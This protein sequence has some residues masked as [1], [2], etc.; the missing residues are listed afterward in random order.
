MKANLEAFAGWF[1]RRA[2]LLVAVAI[3][4]G[5]CANNGQYNYNP[6]ELKGAE[7]LPEPSNSLPE[8]A[9]SEYVISPRDVL[10]VSFLQVPD[11]NRDAL[12]NSKGDVSLAL[13]GNIH[14][15]GKTMVEAQ[16]YITA[17]YTKSYLKSPQITVALSKSG[18]RV[19]MN[20]AVR[21]PTLLTVDGRLTLLQAIAQAGGVSDTANSDRVHIVRTS[22]RSEINDV[23]VSVLKIQL[24]NS[25]DPP[26]YGGDVVVVEQSNAKLAFSSMKELLT[27]STV[28]NYA[29]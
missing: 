15:A 24:G 1:D 14:V 16:R 29:K 22:D 12:V 3:V 9:S 19:A 18:Q 27:F 11:L 2:A 21:S 4:M 10:Q 7:A 6:N 5:G 28:A 26:L 17:Q 25:T 13:V 8:G 23:V 20:G